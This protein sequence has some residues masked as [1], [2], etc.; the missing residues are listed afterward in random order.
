MNNTE[1]INDLAEKIEAIIGEKIVL[2]VATAK[3]ADKG[4]IVRIKMQGMPFEI[5]AMSE[6]LEQAEKTAEMEFMEDFDI[7]RKEKL[8]QTQPK[9]KYKYIKLSDEQLDKL[10]ENEVF[11]GKGF[12]K[13]I[14]EE[15]SAMIC[16]LEDGR[17]ECVIESPYM[18]LRARGRSNTEESAVLAAISV[19]KSILKPTMIEVGKTNN[20][21]N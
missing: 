2:T 17:Y 3:L 21:V 19:A 8:Y 18:Y 7:A 4:Y 16:Q 1:L 14:K 5:S 15:T 12:L 13:R 9:D 10:F 6:T 20:K 11:L